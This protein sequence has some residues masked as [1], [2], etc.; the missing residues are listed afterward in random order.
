LL[1]VSTDKVDTEIPS[2]ASG[3]LTAIKVGEDETVEVGV[4]L[5]TIDESGA[6][7]ATAAPAPV[8][9]PAAQAPAAPP[10]APAPVQVPPPAP[11]PIAQPAPQ[12]VAAAA[13]PAAP[14]PQAP[15][16]PVAPAGGVAAAA[17]PAPPVVSGL[18]VSAGESEE[19]SEDGA[20]GAYVTPLVR[21]LAAEHGVDLS[22]IK[23]TGVG[24]RI[25][26]QDVLEAARAAQPAP[27]PVA[28]SPQ[29]AAATVPAPAV[30]I[31]AAPAPASAI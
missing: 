24:G 20:A 12:P 21:K 22:G 19:E 27:E 8:A 25:R 9:K 2:P 7:A 11:A 29:P 16:Q 3:V 4:E 28:P 5:A 18:A 13:Q 17:P 15:A 26:K 10:A 14:P 6:G 23:G 1:E 30:T 31:P